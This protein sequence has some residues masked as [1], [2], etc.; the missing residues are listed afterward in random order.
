M[1]G[2]A[3]FL[4]VSLPLFTYTTSLALFGLFHVTQELAYVKARFGHR[5]KNQLLIRLVFLLSLVA[6][7]RIL[8]ILHVVPSH[9]SHILEVSLVI[10]LVFSVWPIKGV[11]A[12]SVGMILSI[13]LAI[14][15]LISPT[16]TLLI[17]AI[18]H[19]WT[20]VGFILEATSLKARRQAMAACLLL[21]G[22][23]PLFIASGWPFMLLSK[24]GL[25][26]PEVQILPAGPLASH[27]KA[28]LPEFFHGHTYALYAF[29]AIVF[30]QLLHYGAVIFVLPRFVKEFKQPF[31]VSFLV[32]ALCS[33]LFIYFTMN[34]S[35][36]RSIYGIAAAVHAWLEIPIF[37][38]ILAGLAS[39][40][41]ETYAKR[42]GIGQQGHQE[43]VS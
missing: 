2:L 10:L 40:N 15:V 20:P 31:G 41:Q 11:F 3:F 13:M 21:F 36:A 42:R 18:A 38:V 33:L 30:A 14:G 24:F 23:L 27:F 5:L 12:S 1:A 7:L 6:L 43:A 4:S 34:F 22:I 19:N 37:L 9:Q 29:S 17:L 8:T 28:Y 26:W 25:I 16:V 39:K 35:S 32:L